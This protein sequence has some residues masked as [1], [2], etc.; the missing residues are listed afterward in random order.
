ML[1]CRKFVHLPPPPIQSI[2]KTQKKKCEKSVSFQLFHNLSSTINN[3][4]KLL[5]I[6]RVDHVIKI[7]FA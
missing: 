3:A 1:Q 6:E 4:H 2:G 5:H 7:S